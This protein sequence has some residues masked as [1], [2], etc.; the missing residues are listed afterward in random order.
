MTTAT[1]LRAPI[2]LFARGIP[3][4]YYVGLLAGENDLRAVERTGD[5]RAINRHDYEMAEVEA[6]LRRPVVQRILELV[7]LRAVH[8]A[9]RGGL[10]VEAPDRASLRLTWSHDAARCVL[11]V[12]VVSGQITVTS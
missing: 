11:E 6:A 1:W 4:V 7:R 9:F 8:P 12:D 3:Q 10:T 2:Q 5:G